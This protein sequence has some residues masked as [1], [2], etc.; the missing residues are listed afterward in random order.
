VPALLDFDDV[1]ARHNLIVAGEAAR[2]HREW[3]ARCSDRYHPRTA[4]LVRSG[5]EVEDG[6]LDQALYGRIRL[7][8]ELTA[9]MEAHQ[10]DL[11]ICPSAPGPAP[12]GLASTGDPVMNLPWT[13]AG[14]PALN[15]PSGADPTGLPF[16]LQVVARFQADEMLLAWAEDLVS[17]LESQA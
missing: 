8:E 14:M 7:R 3:F 4:E 11:W 12:R 6:A 15:L 2:V 17:A 1:V 5:Q 16:G 9:L 10:V 13:H